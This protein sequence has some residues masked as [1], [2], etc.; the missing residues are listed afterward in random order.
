MKYENYFEDL[1][2]SFPD[3]RKTFLSFSLIQNKMNFFPE[4]GLSEH[5]INQ[6]NSEFKN[7]L[8]NNL[9]NT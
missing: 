7:I 6:S 4:V 2:E 3:Y 9:K 5:D 8:K 1:F